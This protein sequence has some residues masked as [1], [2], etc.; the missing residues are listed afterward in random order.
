MDTAPVMVADSDTD[1]TEAVTSL[2][3]LGLTDPVDIFEVDSV[4][5]ID[6]L[7]ELLV[8]VDLLKEST[9]GVPSADRDPLPLV[10]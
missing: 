6:V 5:D 3:R 7:S 10:V 2:D 1:S 4:G 9:D 8:D